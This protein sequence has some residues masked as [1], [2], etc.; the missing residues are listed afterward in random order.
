MRHVQAE[1][2]YNVSAFLLEGIRQRRE[3]ILRK[4]LTLVFECFYIVYALIYIIK[5]NALV[6]ILLKNLRGD[7]FFCVTAVKS[8]NIVSRLI[9]RVNR[10]RAGVNNYIVAVQPVPVYHIIS[11]LCQKKRRTAQTLRLLKLCFRAESDPIQKLLAF[12]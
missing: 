5:R 2:L 8:D 4:Q 6:L 12:L 11:P 1:R 10:A 9:D 7:I 3:C